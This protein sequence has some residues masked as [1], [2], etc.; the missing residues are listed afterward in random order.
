MSELGIPRLKN[1]ISDTGAK[2]VAGIDR[3]IDE[4]IRGGTG[5]AM[6]RL[7]GVA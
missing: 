7:L 4:D 5:E 1:E 2:M 3:A 6:M